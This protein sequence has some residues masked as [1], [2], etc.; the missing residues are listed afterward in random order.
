MLGPLDH[1]GRFELRPCRPGAAQRILWWRLGLAAVG[2]CLAL[3]G[4]ADAATTDRAVT[5]SP[6]A[7]ATDEQVEDTTS[8]ALASGE[9]IGGP[10]APAVTAPALVSPQYQAEN[11]DTEP[12][13]S[14]SG[15]SVQTPSA[16]AAGAGS[17]RQIPPAIPQ[18]T[19]AQ[20]VTP[21]PLARALMLARGRVGPSTMHPVPLRGAAT[22]W[23]A[24]SK[25][26]HTSV[27]QYQLQPEISHENVSRVSEHGH[28]IPASRADTPPSTPFHKQSPTP[29][30]TFRMPIS[31]SR[32]NLRQIAVPNQHRIHRLHTQPRA[33]EHLRQ[34]K[35]ALHSDPGTRRTGSSRRPVVAVAHVGDE[36]RLLQIGLALAIVYVVFLGF[37]F[38][39]TREGGRRFEG[40]TRF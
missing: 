31:S 22:S 33:V 19:T 7:L 27:L 5:A 20:P 36:R 24:K 9:P 4:V 34:A 13:I 35:I 21:R 23:H 40:A 37:W 18:R 10:T 14:A 26:Y 16:G 25:R 15:T 2:G 39:G 28:T 11:G 1:P 30:E 29:S 3:A 8:S 17:G 6:A 38:W 12:Q 32:S